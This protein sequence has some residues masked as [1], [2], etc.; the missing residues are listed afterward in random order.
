MH[1]VLILDHSS[2][3]LLHIGQATRCDDDDS[4][5]EDS[6]NEADSEP[7][8]PP[9]QRWHPPRLVPICLVSHLETISIEGFKGQV[10]AIEV[11]KYFLRNGQVLKKM[12]ISSAPLWEG[13]NA[14]YEELLMVLRVSEACMI[15]FV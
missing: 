5:D 11:A 1:A 10:D 15:D 2:L 4:F 12:R 7:E 14:L 9:K 6:E 3:I 8:E 13:K